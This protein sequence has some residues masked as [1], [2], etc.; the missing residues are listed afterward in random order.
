MACHAFLILQ[1]DLKIYLLQEICDSESITFI[2]I[3]AI[4]AFEN[5]FAQSSKR[6]MPNI[7]PNIFYNEGY[8]NAT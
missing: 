1:V 2:M 7:I 5:F 3:I 4:F 8:W 6:R